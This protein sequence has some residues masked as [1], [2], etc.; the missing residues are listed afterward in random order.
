MPLGVV[1]LFEFGIVRDGF[2]AFLLRQDF[3]FGLGI[4]MPLCFQ[5]VRGQ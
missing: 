4:L 2:D 1:D 5:I 3:I